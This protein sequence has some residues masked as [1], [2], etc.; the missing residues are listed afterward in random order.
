MLAY[1]HYLQNHRMSEQEK[2]ENQKTIVAFAAG[3]LIGGLLVWVF[4]GSADTKKVDEETKDTTEQVTEQTKETESTST[5]ETATNTEVAK[6]TLQ[7]V[8]PTR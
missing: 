4:G 3:L 5:E 6:P 8:R 7:M 2:K 1:K